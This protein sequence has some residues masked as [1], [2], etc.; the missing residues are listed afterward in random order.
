MLLQRQLIRI[1]Y[2]QS[3]LFHRY[4]G[5]KNVFKFYDNVTKIEKE[6]KTLEDVPTA[7][8]INDLITRV[9]G[10]P[11]LLYL[12]AFFFSE[13]KKIGILPNNSETRT[14]G[15]RYFS[16]FFIKLTPLHRSFWTT[17]Y[18]LEVACHKHKLHPFKIN[19]IGLLDP[20]NF[21]IDFYNQILTGE[22]NG[23]KYK[24]IISFGFGGPNWEKPKTND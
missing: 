3:L 15:I 14:K 10:H 18:D 21:P 7:V 1:R 19:N 9:Q 2:Q 22:Y 6:Y 24:H 17:C 12:L 4:I 13:C 8:K 16:R 11:E 23:V 20:K 5:F